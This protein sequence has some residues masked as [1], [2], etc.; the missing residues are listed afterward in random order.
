MVGR[1]AYSVVKPV[2]D[3]VSGNEFVAKIVRKDDLHKNAQSERDEVMQ[4]VS[5]LQQLP[6]QRHIV[7]FVELLEQPDEYLV[8]LECLSNGDLCDAILECEDNRMSEAR[9]KSFFV[10]MTEALLCCHS[11]SVSHRDVKPENMLLS[12]N[13]ELKLTDFGLAKSHRNPYRCE[14]SEKTTELVGTLRYAAPELFKGHFDGELYDDYIADVWSLGVC[15]YVMLAGVF[16]F[17]TGRNMDEEGIRDLLC[18]PDEVEMPSCC[19]DKAVALL[20]KMLQKEPSK[21]VDIQDILSDP[22]CKDAWKPSPVPQPSTVRK[23]SLTRDETP[24]LASLPTD[25]QLA[26][27][28]RE[29]LV[30]LA[31]KQHDDADADRKRF[32]ELKSM[33]SDMEAKIIQLEKSNARLLHKLGLAS[34]GGSTSAASGEFATLRSKVKQGTQMLSDMGG[35]SSG[36]KRS[37][38]P[39]SAPRNGYTPSMKPA[40]VSNSP[41]ASRKAPRSMSPGVSTNMRSPDYAYAALSS[42]QPT[43][44]KPRTLSPRP[45]KPSALTPSKGNTSSLSKYSRPDSP[46]MYLS[47]ILAL[48]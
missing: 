37:F 30:S 44:S 36:A 5:I 43:P 12:E 2:T 15:L 13:Y 20:K 14:E 23:T 26:A 1:G 21:R 8:I 19:S 41:I 6:K 46:S 48:F 33:A 34:D 29:E 24:P 3:L 31:K 17:S 27:M 16:P 25:S 39:G 10:M 18:S 11:N 35:G 22:W 38:T 9:V 28:T 32:V 42:P 45:Q 40:S 47:L 4:E 7:E